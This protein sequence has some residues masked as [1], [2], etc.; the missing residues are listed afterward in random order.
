[1]LSS[2]IL[3][4]RNLTLQHLTWWWN[5]QHTIFRCCVTRSDPQLTLVVHC[6]TVKILKI[7]HIYLLT[8]LR[9]SDVSVAPVTVDTVGNLLWGSRQLPIIWLGHIYKRLLIGLFVHLFAIFGQM[10]AVT[11]IFCS[12]QMPYP[13]LL[14]FLCSDLSKFRFK[15]ILFEW[16]SNISLNFLA[17][18]VQK[19]TLMCPWF[20]PLR[21]WKPF[22]FH[23]ILFQFHQTFCLWKN[24]LTLRWPDIYCGYCLSLLQFNLIDVHNTCTVDINSYN[25]KDM[26]ISI[27]NIVYILSS[28]GS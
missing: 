2:S 1:M 9:V 14:E 4:K 25:T 23:S 24:V 27:E 8:L 21:S 13:S 10:E 19:E 5:C 28:S 6:Q 15:S 11:L 17:K 16:R 7:C 12:L 18:M 22:Q 26:N 20:L 3:V